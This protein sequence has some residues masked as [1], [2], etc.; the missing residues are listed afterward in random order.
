MSSTRDACHGQYIERD[1][2]LGLIGVLETVI[3]SPL[4]LGSLGSIET[5]HCQGLTIGQII[6]FLR[7]RR[8]SRI[9]ICELGWLSAMTTFSTIRCDS[10]GYVLAMRTDIEAPWH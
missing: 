2:R 5:V 9:E 10:D 7:W 8:G 3:L 6:A 4:C 1:I